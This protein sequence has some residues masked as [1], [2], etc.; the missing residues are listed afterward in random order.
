MHHK[1]VTS[2]DKRIVVR[3]YSLS[4]KGTFFRELIVSEVKIYYFNQVEINYL[5]V[6]ISVY[7]FPHILRTN[8]G[9]IHSTGPRGK[10]R[11]Q[12]LI[13]QEKPFSFMEFLTILET[14]LSG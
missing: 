5:N 8:P 9:P 4:A 11:D 10:R 7:G 14:L 3:R 12:S 2:G 13:A 6:S 1:A